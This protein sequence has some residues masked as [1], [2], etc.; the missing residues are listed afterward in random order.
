MIGG[1]NLKK[2]FVDSFEEY[3]ELLKDG[4]ELVSIS[5]WLSGT[6]RFTYCLAKYDDK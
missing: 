1:D 5:Y 3:S 2:V 4:Y 6:V